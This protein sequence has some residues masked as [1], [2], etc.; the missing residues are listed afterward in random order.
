MLPLFLALG[1]SVD[2]AP[3]V[4]A[5]GL[6][7]IR[8]G[9]AETATKGVIEHA[10]ILVEDGK[11]VTIGEDLPIERGI[12]ILDKPDWVV[13]P[14]LVDAYSRLGLDG[15]GGDD[16]SPQVRASSEIY[17]GAEV[18]E[19]VVEYGVT[20]VGLYPAGNGITG[21]AVAIRPRGKTREE[22]VI[23]DPAYLK[24]IL[25]ASASSKKQLKD[26]F[27]KADEYREK[28]KKAREKWDKDQ[29]KKKKPPAKKD[30]KADEK[31][32]EEKKDEKKEAEESAAAQDDK[33]EK[34]EEKKDEKPPAKDDVFVPPAPDPKVK[35]FLDLRSGS[36]RALFSISSSADY[37][38]LLDALGDEK[39]EFD[40]RI[41][42]S[43]ESDVFYVADKKTHELDV[44]G[45]GDRKCRVVLE[46]TLTYHP[47]TMRQRNLPMELSRAGAKVV[48]VPR[49]DDLGRLKT[50]LS[51][52]GELIGAGLD[53][54]TALRAM[55]SEPAALLG[56]GDR[57][58]SLEKGKDANLVFLSG[59]PFEPATRIRAVML[60]GRF[61]FGEVNL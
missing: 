33:D 35:P 21:Q 23:L 47:G 44:D 8:V 3:P 24:I 58:G 22:M 46:P 9:R 55:T 29:E 36:L 7:A 42:W 27:K 13:I 34:K 19:K 39:I 52:V 2:P 5:G 43:R 56:L 25:R 51:D 45:I 17:P 32:T 20:T 10:V 12:P 1:A 28:E 15:E 48:F 40:L 31:K 26:G 11:I 54:E 61:V 59:D 60:D 16:N 53:R 57:L 50:W 6:L 14:G 49:D 41:P 30:E 18:Y 38:H 37:L 4:R